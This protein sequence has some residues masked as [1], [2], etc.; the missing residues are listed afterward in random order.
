MKAQPMSNLNSA[1]QPLTSAGGQDPAVTAE[2][3]EARPR[4]LVVDDVA[5]N[6][7]IL[8]RR[9]VRRGFDA[10]E[11]A[12]GREALTLL[13]ERKFD[14]VLL[15]IMMPDIN[16]NDVLRVIRQTY[17]DIELPVI[18]VSAKSQSEDVV[19]S[20][21]LG[22]NDYVTKPIDFSVALARINGQLARK[23]ASDAE[24]EMLQ[25]LEEA[26]RNLHDEVERESG[27]RRHSEE[28]LQYLAYH[29]ALTGLLNR[30]AFRDA[31]NQ[32]L[33]N[34]PV[35]DFEP[36]L[37]FIDLNRFKAVND[38]Y[39]HEIGD[40]LI[41]AVAERLK[42]VV[43]EGVLLG[44]LG[45]D[46]FGA[47]IL[48]DSDT[49][50]HSLEEARRI[51]S[52]LSKPFVIDDHSFTIGASCGIAHASVCSGDLDVLIKAADLAMYHAKSN[53]RGGAVLFEPRM[54]EE[55]EE[56]R[57]LERDLRTAVQQGG[58]EVFYQPMI[59]LKT[60]SITGFEALLRWPHP[61]RGMI[62]PETFIPIAEDT[63]LIIPMGDWVLRQAL[64]EAT[65]WPK[66]ITIAVNL[67]PLQLRHPALVPSVVNALA[68]TGLDPR[69]LELEIT[70]TGLLSA[71]R[72]SREIVRTLRGFGIRISIDDFGTGYS[73]MSYLQNF[74]IDKI[75]IDKGFVQK[76]ETSASSSAIIQ[77]IID[78]GVNVGVGTAAE[79][80]ETEEQLH[81]VEEKGC[82]QVQ[83]YLFSRPLTAQDAR[84]YISESKEGPAQRSE[85]GSDG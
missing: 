21:G 35:S 25:D 72:Y 73:S 78:L 6:R 68:A 10:I 83:G 11:A 36:V 9:L 85:P 19:E 49:A 55:L 66:N 51:V 84:R 22:A 45:G 27:R 29:D 34:I 79:G 42:D 58:F 13:A 40:Q 54:L 16:G 82:T 64:S 5:D 67:S 15:D 59:D 57:T 63:G 62:G 2:G 23:R 44:R 28:R 33:D 14:I 26:T 24:H 41:K 65:T 18:M 4:I 60:G 70:E 80:I 31:L 8:V 61:T 39:G 56:R 47:M 71:E 75:K 1:A 7:D 17:S 43:D 30:A 52:A 12:G 37:L 69:R 38:T 32:A 76:L 77:A 50:S 46:E 3:T 20:L 48:E 81:S 74:E 53:N